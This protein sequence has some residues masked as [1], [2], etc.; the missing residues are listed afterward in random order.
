MFHVGISKHYLTKRWR[1]L[2]D[3]KINSNQDGSPTE[4]KN[5]F[6]DN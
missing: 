2:I 3:R 6:D 5:I 1:E 4:K